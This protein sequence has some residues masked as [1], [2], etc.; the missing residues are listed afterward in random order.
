MSAGKRL[1]VDELDAGSR[2]TAQLQCKAV[3]WGKGERGGIGRIEW[4]RQAKAAGGRGEH[5]TSYRYTTGCRCDPC[6]DARNEYAREWADRRR[7]NDMAKAK[8]VVRK[9][10]T[11]LF[12]FDLVGP[13]GKVIATSQAY[14]SRSSALRGIESVREYAARAELVD[15]AD[16]GRGQ[17]SQEEKTQAGASDH[18]VRPWERHL[19]EAVRGDVVPALDPR[20][21]DIAPIER[22]SET[23][24]ASHSPSGH[25][26]RA[27]DTCAVDDN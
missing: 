2:V 13:N 20:I 26:V 22:N 24:N 1:L 18:C 25:S 16:A 14:Q 21:A 8:F 11:G 10:R 3:A 4:Y 19:D 17:R 9:G 27:F 7:A 23:S 12:G 5:G 15:Q 6:R